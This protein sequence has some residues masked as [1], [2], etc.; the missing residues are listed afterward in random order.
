MKQ[1]EG[2][3]LDIQ[4]GCARDSWYAKDAVAEGFDSDAEEIGSDL[5][6]IQLRNRDRP[7]L[8]GLELDD[9]SGELVARAAP[10]DEPDVLFRLNQGAFLQVL[11]YG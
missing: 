9:Y 11:A 3:R 4:P 1:L 2:I 10:C 6:Q 7:L 8:S 5:G